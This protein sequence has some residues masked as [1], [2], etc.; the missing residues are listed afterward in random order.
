MIFVNLLIS[1]SHQFV[2]SLTNKNYIFFDTHFWNYKSSISFFFSF[3]FFQE[4]CGAVLIKYFFENVAQDNF[5]NFIIQSTLAVSKVS[6]STYWVMLQTQTVLQHFY[7]MLMW[8][9]SYWFSSKSI[10]NITF[11]FTNNHS[12][13]QQLIKKIIK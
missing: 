11:S 4:L 12:P 6:W 8:P 9:T 2:C 5:G 13:H 7:K 3:F 10:I 1:F